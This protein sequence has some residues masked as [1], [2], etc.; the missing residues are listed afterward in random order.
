MK[1]NTT[2]KVKAK[3]ASKSTPAAKKSSVS[4]KDK[5]TVRSKSHTV[6]VSPARKI[7]VAAPTKNASRKPAVAPPAA[8]T[9]PA[10]VQQKGISRNGKQLPENN[11]KAQKS[12]AKIDPIAKKSVPAPPPPEA[13]QP[14]KTYLIAKELKEFK[15]LL[16]A[17][18]AE[19]A[20]D[21]ENLTSEALNRKFGG[22]NE[23]SSMPI[24]M[25]DLGSD[26]WEQDF[27]LGLIANEQALVREIDDALARIEDKTYGICVATDKPISME[28]LRAKPWAK[29]CIE[30]A[31]LRE[32]GRAP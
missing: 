15:G 27:T 4:L 19:L 12:Q 22:A 30:Y 11:R 10:Q 32:E 7:A 16:L 9:A 5:K 14:V 24:H 8:R 20:G 21:V 1:K 2:K 26:T 17:K 18:R 13:A 25:A 3:S 29:Y 23:Q 31:R 28:R 6:P